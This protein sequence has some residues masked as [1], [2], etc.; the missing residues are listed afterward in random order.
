MINDFIILESENTTSKETTGLSP[1]KKN[2]VTQTIKDYR[3]EA[4]ALTVASDVTKMLGLIL[5]LVA[6]TALLF[7]QAEENA[8]PLKLKPVGYFRK[9][10][11]EQ[12]DPEPDRTVF[13][14]KLE[15]FV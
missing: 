4:N 5:P 6:G 14:N 13:F 12:K 2:L 9:R 15:N 1:N 3:K 11:I 7:I 10:K 8:G